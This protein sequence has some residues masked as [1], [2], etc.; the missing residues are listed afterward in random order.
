MSAVRGGASDQYAVLMRRY[1]QRVYR[2]ARSIVRDDPEA[3]DVAQQAFVTGYQ[4]LAQ[5]EDGNR[6]AAWVTR[7]AANEALGRLRKR[8][9]TTP[10]ADVELVA[11][12]GPASGGPEQAAS[13]RE[14]TVLLERAVDGL[15]EAYRAVFVLRD[16]EEL[17]TADTAS[18]LGISEGSVRVRLHRARAA[19]RQTIDE[20]TG[21][22][23]GDIF[24][25][26]GDRCDRIVAGV[27]AR[28]QP[29]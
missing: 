26:A 2:V 15:P 23:A 6:F 10:L 9:R 1:N 28:I 18:A 20:L 13:L 22:A 7:I 16:V 5:L 19:L 29:D 4:R 12:E 24:G 17:T 21:L 11:D 27:F 3:E 14:L 8:R 25:F